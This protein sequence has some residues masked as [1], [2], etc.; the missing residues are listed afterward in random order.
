MSQPWSAIRSILQLCTSMP[1]TIMILINCLC[2]W[3]VSVNLVYLMTLTIQYYTFT[4][5][6]RQCVMYVFTCL[7]T[8]VIIPL[9]CWL[10]KIWFAT[11]SLLF[12]KQLNF[13]SFENKFFFFYCTIFVCNLSIP[14]F[15]TKYPYFW[16]KNNYLQT[17]SSRSS[18]TFPRIDSDKTLTSMVSFLNISSALRR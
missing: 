12:K 10:V 17:F 3:I 14:I 15:D 16:C 1:L 5:L 8:H 6:T 7:S 2:R 9:T 11:F 13:F 4:T 18:I